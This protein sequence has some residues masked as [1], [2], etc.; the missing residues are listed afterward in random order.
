M[1]TPVWRLKGLTGS[2]PGHLELREGRLRYTPIE[3]GRP[4]FD[5]PFAEVSDVHFPW[6]YFG[7]GFKMRIGGEEFRF[8]F[9]EPHNDLADV[10]GGRAAGKQ[11]RKL[12]NP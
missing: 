5:A 12:L 11:W 3:P 10:A 2:E 6:H 8:S 1:L 4:G 7:G 9:I